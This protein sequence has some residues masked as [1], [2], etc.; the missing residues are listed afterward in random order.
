[1]T[2]Q[3][4]IILMKI[5]IQTTPESVVEDDDITNKMQSYRNKKFGK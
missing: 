2:R 5:S 4:T 1:M 3:M